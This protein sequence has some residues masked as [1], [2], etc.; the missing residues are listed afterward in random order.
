MRKIFI[1]FFLF[2]LSCAKPTVIETEQPNDQKLNCEELEF[3]IAEAQKIK[4]EANF[5][6]DSGGNIARIIL[7]WPAWAQSL[8][9]A[10]E[11]MIAANNRTFHL[12]KVMKSKNCKNAEKY[13]AVLKESNSFKSRENIAEQLQTLKSL[14]ENG[15][16]TE[17]EYKK[18]KNKVLN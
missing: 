5:S 12:I 6:K 14:Y 13:K 4:E 18:A 1:L 8:H 15:D 3:E 2:T 11:A 16:L 7:F 9:N 10:D 17:E